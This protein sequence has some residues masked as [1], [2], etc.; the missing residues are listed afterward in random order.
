MPGG[1][2]PLTAANGE[3]AQS[4]QSTRFGTEGPQVRILSS[5]PFAKG[6]ATVDVNWSLP[7]KHAAEC[8]TCECCGEPWCAECGEHYAEC[9]HPGPHTDPDDEDD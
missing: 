8:E 7:V 2:I 4:G 5:P 1:S 6:E 3:V 9:A